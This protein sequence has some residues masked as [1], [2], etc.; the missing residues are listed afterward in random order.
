[1]IKSTLL[2]SRFF[3]RY[4]VV[5]RDPCALASARTSQGGRKSLDHEQRDCLYSQPDQGI[6]L[7]LIAFLPFPHSVGCLK[8]YGKTKGE[9]GW[10]RG[11]E[12]AIAK[13]SWG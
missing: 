5:G 10:N 6:F 11:M 3:G 13:V 8:S 9:I 1:M 12:Q 4:L 2:L 7:G